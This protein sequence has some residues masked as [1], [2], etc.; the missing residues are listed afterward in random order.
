M[1]DMV[2]NTTYNSIQD[3]TND[4]GTPAGQ[5]K[6]KNVMPIKNTFCPEHGVIWVIGVAR[7]DTWNVQ[8]S[9][10]PLMAK[11]DQEHFYSPEYETGKLQDWNQ[12][13]MG[14]SNV[15]GCKT[16]KYEDYRKLPNLIGLGPAATPNSFY[17]HSWDNASAGPGNYWEGTGHNIDAVFNGNLGTGGADHFN[18]MTEI[19][20]SRRSPVKPPASI[21]GVS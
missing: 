3:V 17:Y 11:T 21:S 9:T 16:R 6:T 15:F 10:H 19:R 20:M 18:V 5:Y 12:K 8:G 14:V 13:I 2:H 7:M 1:A 4:L